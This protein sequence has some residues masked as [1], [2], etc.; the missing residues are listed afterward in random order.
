MEDKSVPDNLDNPKT[1]TKRSSK[2]LSI[3][4]IAIITII[5]ILSIIGL[6]KLVIKKD[7]KDL[8]QEVFLLSDKS[9]LLF[10]DDENYILN[11]NYKDKDITMY[12]KY[13]VSYDEDINE[14]VKYSYKTYIEEFKRKDYNLSFLELQNEE[15]YINNEKS[16]N[17]YINMYY[18][19]MLYDE[20]GK[21]QL[22]G[23]N[24]DTGIKVKFEK[25]EK[26]FNKYYNEIMKG[27]QI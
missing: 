26:Q 15:L 20:D 22:L 24:V 27:V 9:T 11:Y 7:K 18:I 1:E 10:V 2:R 12:G 16:E 23:Y 5:V 14:N 13:R 6:L 4:S 19:L 8:S 25:Q 21:A 3:F 17:G